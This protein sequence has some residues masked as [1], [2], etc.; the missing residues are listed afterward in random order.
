M[1]Q[2]ELSDVAGRIVRD[3]AEVVPG[4]DVLVVTD[5]RSIDVARPIANAARAVTDG[6]VLSVMPVADAHGNE[7]PAVVA[8]G[9]L[10]ADIVFAVTD[11]ALTHSSA[12]QASIEAGTRTYVLRGVTTEMMIEGGIDTDYGELTR[13]T[14]AVSELL[15]AADS[16]HVTSP[17]GT[18]VRMSLAGR[19]GFVLDGR[20]YDDGR[21]AAAIPTGEAPIGPVEGTAEGTIVVDYSMDNVGR[22]AEPIELSV[23]GGEVTAI[24]GGEEADRLREIVEGA[25]PNAG[26]VAE[27]AI[28]TNPDA[29]LIGNLAEDKKRAG[30]V[31]FAVGDNRGLDGSV[32]SD[33]HLDGL[34][35]E[36]TVRLDGEAVVVDGELQLDRILDDP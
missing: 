12:R 8:E 9:M 20:F 22:L 25:D 13:V 1:Y 31:H 33:I 35:T 11:K 21:A 18:D 28:G 23:A 2:F 14:T 4:E 19:D 26:N 15:T 5:A 3:M 10:A 30:T 6:T 17:D 24:A 27:F 29:R 16:A 32:A 36:P 34:V 7:P